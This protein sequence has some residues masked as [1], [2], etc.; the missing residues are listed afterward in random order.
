M[1]KILNY[2][3]ILFI[4]F[5]LIAYLLELSL[6]LFLPDAQKGLVK[7]KETR[8]DIAKKLVAIQGP[9][10]KTIAALSLFEIPVADNCLEILLI[11]FFKSL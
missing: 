6:F 8:L 7:I 1:K 4:N 9:F 3:K 2:L 10:G 5:I 11:N